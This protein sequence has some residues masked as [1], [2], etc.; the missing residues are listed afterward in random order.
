MYEEKNR[1]SRLKNGDEYTYER[2]FRFGVSRSSRDRL[3]SDN[4][5][6][7]DHEIIVRLSKILKSRD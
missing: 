5:G 4:L 7:P 6:P 3:F 2:Q 1:P